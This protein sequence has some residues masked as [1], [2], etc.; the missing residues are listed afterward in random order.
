[1][2]LPVMAGRLPE[3]AVPVGAQVAEDA[4]AVTRHPSRTRSR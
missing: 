2:A 1:M 3:E 4:A